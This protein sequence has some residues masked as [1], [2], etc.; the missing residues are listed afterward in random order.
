MIFIQIV[1]IM[2]ISIITLMIILIIT[3]IIDH[4][5]ISFPGASLPPPLPLH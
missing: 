2:S 4:L 3:L 5:T 1:I